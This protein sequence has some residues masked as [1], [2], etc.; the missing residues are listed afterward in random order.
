MK[1]LFTHSDYITWCCEDMQTWMHDNR[2]PLDLGVATRTFFLP[3]VWP[4]E[5]PGLRINFCPWCGKPLPTLQEKR[6]EILEKEYNIE[7]FFDP[8]IP[9]E[10]NTE[11]WWVKRGL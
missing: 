7:N 2:F 11:E 3:E 9:E 6:W 8:R 5:G 1:K 10:F 4:H